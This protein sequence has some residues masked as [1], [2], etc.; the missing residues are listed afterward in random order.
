MQLSFAALSLNVAG[1]LVLGVQADGVFTPSA[2]EADKAAG[3]A[4][5][6]AV[7]ASS[8]F[9]GKTGQVVEVLAPP[10]L[11]ASRVL[12]VGMGK[13]EDFNGG[14]AERLAA[15]VVARLYTNGT[16]AIAFAIDAPKGAKLKPAA[17]AAHLA[18]GAKLRSY[19][20][21]QYRTK[22]R[23][24]Y[25]MTIKT[26]AIGTRDVPGAKK[27]WPAMEA[28]VD[29]VFLARGLINEPPNV[30]YPAEFANRAKQLSKLGLKVEV[31]GEAQMKKLGMG[32]LLGVGQGSER[33]SQL[34]VMRWNGAR[35]KDEAPV[36]F[37]GKGVCFDSGGLSLKPGASMMGMKGDMGGAAAVTGTMRALAARKAKVNAVGVIG[38]VENMPDGKAM[39]PDDVVTSM[40]GQTIEVLNTDAEG[41]LVLAD[42]LT[43]TQ[44]KFKPKFVIDLATLTGAIMIALGN[45]H[46]GLFSNNDQLSTRLTDAGKAVGEPVWRLPLGDAYDKLIKSKIADMKNIGGPYAGSIV[47]AQFL[48]RFV[49]KGQ[50]WAHLDI[51]GVAWQDGEQKPLSPG[52][53]VGWGVRTLDRLVA[54][55]YEK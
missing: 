2:M 37:V 32:S 33:E 46:A 15:S 53:G 55:N 22:A 26:V 16:P 9:S 6:R 11:K 50:A 23:D 14:S 30:L 21:T 13:G 10:G 44:R 39:R 47:A 41:R 18:M 54:D 49:E 19:G 36:A 29:S 3:G 27:A 51:A 12:L 4:L 28:V 40:S 35:K 7:A 1:A 20:F 31:L 34:V 5:K 43:Y 17:L 42:A 52:W 48:Q 25:E 45:D 38:L 8:K 24:E